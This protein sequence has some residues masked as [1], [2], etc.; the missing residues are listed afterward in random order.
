MTTRAHDYAAPVIR[1]GNTGQGTASHTSYDRRY[2]GLVAGKPDLV[3]S[4]DPAFRGEAD[5]QPP[6]RPRLVQR[7][8]PAPAHD[9]GARSHVGRSTGADPRGRPC[10]AHRIT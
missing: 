1:D 5:S 7:A 2:R 8:Q 9:P 3:G 10:A 4:A 6:G